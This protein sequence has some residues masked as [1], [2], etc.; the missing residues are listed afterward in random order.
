MVVYVGCVGGGDGTA[1]WCKSQRSALAGRDSCSAQRAAG[2]RCEG[3]GN[4]AGCAAHGLSASKQ[5]SLLLSRGN[6]LGECREGVVAHLLLGHELI[7]GRQR[8]LLRVVDAA[9]LVA[10]RRR[11]RNVLL[12]QGRLQ[13]GRTGREGVGVRAWAAQQ[14]PRAFR[15]SLAKVGEPPRLVCPL[16][17]PRE[18]A[19]TEPSRD[20]T[21]GFSPH[22]ASRK[23]PPPHPHP[24]PPTQTLLTVTWRKR[25][26]QRCGG[27]YTPCMLRLRLS[28]SDT[29][30]RG[31]GGGQPVKRL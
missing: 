10:G 9:D 14:Q 15:S 20:T 2:C 29:C 8:L 28:T 12:Q 7:Q 11:R 26:L 17:R 1:G 4:R 19:L 23:P 13:Q 24:T 18:S 27:R 6:N 5:S 25:C 21:L 22:V 16:K 30:A 3:P 31:G